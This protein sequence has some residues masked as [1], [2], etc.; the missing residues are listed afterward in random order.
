[1]KRFAPYLL[2]LAL[3]ASA[4]HAD[5][6]L[7]AR[8]FDARGRAHYTAGDFAEALRAFLHAHR[9]APSPPRSSTSRSR[10]SSAEKTSS[11]GARSSPTAPRRPKTRHSARTRPVDNAPWRRVSPC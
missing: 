8:Y 6:A 3:T 9:I 1:M 4:A 11:P 10:L 5:S 7:D 2:L